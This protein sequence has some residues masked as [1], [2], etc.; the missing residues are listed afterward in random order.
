MQDT[1][2]GKAKDMNTLSVNARYTIGIGICMTLYALIL[3]ASLHAIRYQHPTGLWLDILAIAPALP[4]GGTII[5][6]QRH[7]DKLDEYVRGV[8]TKRF[9]TATGVTLFLCTAVGFWKNGTGQTIMQM[10]LVYPAF[11][12]AFG[13]ASLIHRKVA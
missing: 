2:C 13:V 12:V 10:Y 9:I 6:F 1:P 11:W 8:L 7:L 5:V 3:V 4:I